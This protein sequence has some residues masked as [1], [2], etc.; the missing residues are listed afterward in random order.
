MNMQELEPENLPNAI[1]WFI[2][3]GVIQKKY[4]KEEEQD[5]MRLRQ[6]E[7]QFVDFKKDMK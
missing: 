4:I 7:Y 5:S 2:K 3:N 6:G 1:R